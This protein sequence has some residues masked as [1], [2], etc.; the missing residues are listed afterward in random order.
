MRPP[1]TASYKVIHEQTPFCSESPVLSF[2]SFLPKKREENETDCAVDPWMG[3]VQL[4]PG[5]HI[6]QLHLV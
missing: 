2:A 6:I 5:L 4:T 1:S 3:P